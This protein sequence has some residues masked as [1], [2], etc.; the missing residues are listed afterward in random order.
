[1]T[2]LERLSDQ[3]LRY[4]TEIDCADHMAWVA[5]DPAQ[6]AHPGVSAGHKPGGAAG[7]PNRTSLQSRTLSPSGC[8][9]TTTA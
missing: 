7:H 3:Q 5:L 2:P 6:P 1:M 8:P 4:L 9:G